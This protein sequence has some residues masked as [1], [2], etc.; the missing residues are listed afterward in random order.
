[1]IFRSNFEIIVSIISFS[2]DSYICNLVLTLQIFISFFRLLTT[3]EEVPKKLA[4]KLCV[5]YYLLKILLQ[6]LYY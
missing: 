1:M 3:S 5:F 4:L 6:I 2:N